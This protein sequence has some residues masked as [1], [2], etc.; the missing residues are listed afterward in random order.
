[1][2]FLLHV[3][4][5]G[6]L[7]KY[8]NTFL[9]ERRPVSRLFFWGYSIGMILLGII[10]NGIENASLNL[11]L[12]CCCIFFTGLW[13]CGKIGFRICYFCVYLGIGVISEIMT[14]LLNGNILLDT[15]DLN[16]FLAMAICQGIKYTIIMLLGTFKTEKNENLP[17]GTTV[18]MCIIFMGATAGCIL[19]NW[20][21]VLNTQTISLLSVLAIVITY[22]LIFFLVFVLLDRF[23][24][25]A[26]L[27]Y[28][29][30]LRI[31]ENCLKESY[32]REIDENN[33]QLRKIK[34]DLKNKLLVFSNLRSNEVDVVKEMIS[35][36][37]LEIN[38]LEGQIYTQNNAINAICKVKFSDAKKKKI[39]IDYDISLPEYINISYGDLGILY[40]NLLDNAM[41][42]CEKLE[43]ESRYI[44]IITKLYNESLLL[45]IE[46][47]KDSS[48]FSEEKY[49]TTKRDRKNHG[50]GIK[51]VR[52][53]VERYH[54][55]IHISSDTDKFKVE[56]VLYGIMSRLNPNI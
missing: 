54:G 18:I 51:S 10:V 48:L 13:Y 44:S 16:Y 25:S 8:Y 39:P 52:E 4:D 2:T 50:F 46:N 14:L 19:I 31:Q 37:L 5:Y 42:A 26:R 28:E 21:S 38:E 22:L 12:S 40:G 17:K 29:Q 6:I 53:V 15:N 45:S 43:E 7:V 36:V 41:D 9:G 23:S 1:M 33:L 30:S 27:N 3:L 55:T 11:V 32:Y 47:S 35:S 56:I 34:H 24:V 49:F 20:N